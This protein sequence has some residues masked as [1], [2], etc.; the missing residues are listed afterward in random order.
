MMKR[1]MY[2]CCLLLSIFFLASGGFAAATDAPKEKSSK[3]LSQMLLDIEVA[4][5]TAEAEVARLPSVVDDECSRIKNALDRWATTRLRAIVEANYADIRKALAETSLPQEEGAFSVWWKQTKAGVGSNEDLENLMKTYFSLLQPRLSSVS[6]GFQRTILDDLE[7]ETT[8]NL[9][10]SMERIRKPFLGVLKQ[11][12]PVYNTI[13]V[14][15]TDRATTSVSSGKMGD[16]SRGSIPVKGL[17]GAAFVLL[18]KKIITRIMKFLALKISGK[19]L[20]KLLPAVGWIL[21]AFEVY[22]MAGARDRFEEEMR[23]AFFE[24]YTAEISAESLWWKGEEGATPSMRDEINRNVCS[25]LKNWERICQS[26]AASMIQSAHILSFS[27]PVREYVSKEI[28][29]GAEFEPVLQKMGIL[30]DVFGPLL[31]QGPISGF[32]SMLLAAPDRKD[33]RLLSKSMGLGLLEMYGKYGKDFLQ[34]VNKIGVQNF[35]SV[36]E[37]ADNKIDWRLLNERFSLLP[38]LYENR[39]ASVG[40]LSLVQEDAPIEGVS[41][42][43]MARIAANRELFRKIW[44]I[45]K[46]DIEKTTL[47]IGNKKAVSNIGESLAAFPASAEAFLKSY[48]PEFWTAWSRD[49]IAVLLQITE[50]RSANYGKAPELSLVAP[51]D[52]AELITVFRQAGKPGIALWDIYATKDSGMLGKNRARQAVA[53]LSDGYDFEDLKDR[54]RLEFAITC[55]KIPVIDRII[56]N[57]FKQLGQIPRILVVAAS[58]VMVL[59]MIFALFRRK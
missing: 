44:R 37:W 46:P 41:P 10:E 2:V 7:K 28:D 26:E 59:G 38:D 33:L 35:L 27:E 34:G 9:R 18:G 6:E 45:L 43:S 21:L 49:D 40:L 47:L 22:D 58:V 17:V 48:G 51:E 15:N 32:E 55:R 31:A 8:S 42:E 36:G 13:P 3:A 29:G 24:E 4:A 50:F 30:W 5:K 20:A 1:T 57:N 19:V 56:Y 39:E 16:F 14:P 23:R 53:C 25:L 54:E 52:R 12:L 11:R